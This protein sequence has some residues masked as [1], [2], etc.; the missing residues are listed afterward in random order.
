MIATWSGRLWRTPSRMAAREKRGPGQRHAQPRFR[1]GDHRVRLLAAEPEGA[2]GDVAREAGPGQ[3]AELPEMP[4]G[5]R[6]IVR[7]GLRAIGAEPPPLGV[8]ERHG[9]VLLRPR[10]G[11]ACQG[12]VHALGGQVRRRRCAATVPPAR[13]GP[14]APRRRRHRRSARPPPRPAPP[15]APPPERRAWRT[16]RPRPRSPRAAPIA[17]HGGSAPGPA[18]PRWWRKRDRCRRAASFRRARSG[19]G[20]AGFCT[21][22]M[23]AASHVETPAGTGGTGMAG[24][25]P[26]HERACP[27][28]WPDSTR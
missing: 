9:Q 14:P 2:F 28:A 1:A 19:A 7:S 21:V 10:Q 23:G 12:R 27:R 8:G 16:P 15:A 22:G 24:V 3:C 20:P 26:R 13:A 25:G 11:L 17:A 6:R 18:R 4:L 5:C